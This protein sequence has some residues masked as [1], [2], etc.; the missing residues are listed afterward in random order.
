MPLDDDADWPGLTAQGLA[1]VFQELPAEVLPEYRTRRPYI[2]ALLARHE[3]DR[4]KPGSRPLFWRTQ[5][6]VY[7]LDPKLRLRIGEVFHPVYDLLFPPPLRAYGPPAVREF[8]E[9]P[10]SFI[11]P[12]ERSLM[13]LRAEREAERMAK[14]ARWEKWRLEDARWQAVRAKEAVAREAA[15]LAR[16][17]RTDE[18]R[19]RKEAAARQVQATPVPLFPFEDE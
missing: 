16:I 3:R 17:A 12:L 11:S 13:A 8:I 1:K 14:E 10:A 2:S 9:Q 4:S 15:R 5:R 7:V 19:K 6:G 18:A